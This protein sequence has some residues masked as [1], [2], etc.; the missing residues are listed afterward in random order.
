[1][2]SEKRRHEVYEVVQRLVAEGEL[3]N[4]LKKNMKMLDKARAAKVRFARHSSSLTAEKC[5]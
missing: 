2:R 5:A 3:S 1:M 4:L